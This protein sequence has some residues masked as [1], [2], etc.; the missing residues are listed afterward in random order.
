MFYL[1]NRRGLVAA[2]TACAVHSLY[3][4]RA[5]SKITMTNNH[6]YI[7]LYVNH[8]WKYQKWI[9]L[10]INKIIKCDKTRR[11]W[12]VG[13]LPYIYGKKKKKKKDRVGIYHPYQPSLPRKRPCSGVC[14]RNIFVLGSSDP[15]ETCNILQNK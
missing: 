11:V 14:L 10:F 2:V 12:T 6:C 5:K 9:I 15:P 1:Y 7:M 3:Y 8:N 13:I 4:L